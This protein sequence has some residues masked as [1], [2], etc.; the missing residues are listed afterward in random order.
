MTYQPDRESLKRHQA[1]EWFHDAKLGIFVHWG[2]YSVPA[3]APTEQGDITETLKRGSRHHFA[4]NPYAEWYL[5]TLRL[6]GSPARVHHEATYGDG[7]AYDDFVQPYNAALRNWDPDA[8]AE[9]FAATGAQYV[10]LTTKHHDGF[11]LWPSRTPNPVKRGY[12]ANRDIVGELAEAV[13]A[14][15]M[16]MGLYYSGLLDWSFSEQPI[17]SFVGLLDN[18]PSGP[19]YAAYADAHFYELIE[20]YTP[21]VL[22]NDIGYPVEGQPERIMAHFYNAIPD[23]AVND[24]WTTT[25]M[26]ARRLLGLRPIRR[27]ADRLIHRM[28]TSEGATGSVPTNAHYDFRTPEYASFSEI[29]AEKWECC[30]GLGRSFG[31]NQMESDEHHISVTELVHSFVDIVSKNGNLLL[32]VGPTADGTIPGPQRKRLEGLGAWLEVNGEAIFGSRPWARAEG[33]SDQGVPIRFTRRADYLYAIVLGAPSGPITVHGVRSATGAEVHQLGHAEPLRWE[34]RGE[35]LHVLL[36]DT[37]PDLC[38]V[39]LRIPQ[40]GIGTLR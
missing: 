30:R 33:T 21:S 1:P 31:Y 12:Q 18:G 24:R 10:V 19:E 2:L 27:L 3:F 34:Q 14:T 28:M 4:H 36:P 15:S 9:T 23:G 11:L 40:R 35:D 22:W 25:P 29:R 8:M 5:N 13:R 17:D 16:R 32:N 6:E 37:V 39:T 20:R 7:F 26:W 38:A